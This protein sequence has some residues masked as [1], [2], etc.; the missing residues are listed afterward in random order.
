VKPSILVGY[1]PA[2]GLAADS[3][4]AAYAVVYV[5]PETNTVLYERAI[6]A[7]IRAR[8]DAIVYA[9]NLNGSLF[10]QDGILQDHYVTQLRFAS[11]PRAEAVRYPE[12]GEKLRRHFGAPLAEL[13]LDGA[14]RA[15]ERST[16][17]ELFETFVPPADFLACWG[18]QFKRI[19]GTVVANPGLPAVLKRYTPEAN[20]FVVVVR[21]ADGSPEFFSDLNGVIYREITSRAE[22]PLVDG[23]RLGSVPWPERVRRTYHLSRS[24]LMAMFDMSDF[25]YLSE[26]RRL[27]IAETPLGKSLLTEGILTAEKLEDLKRDPLRYA[28]DADP[29]LLHYLPLVGEGRGLDWLR[30]FLRE[31]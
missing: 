27:A 3:G 14:F 2:E 19:G 15:A 16:E 23:E 29:R 10:R 22:T 20:V 13:P 21:S 24:H 6:V 11:D 12:I 26:G 4:A 8:G 17:E 31:L 9:A 25:V 5:R 28:R 7:V 18:Q 30:G 1:P